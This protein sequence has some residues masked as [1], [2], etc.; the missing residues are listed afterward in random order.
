MAMSLWPHFLAHPVISPQLLTFT[1]R[2]YY[3][4]FLNVTLAGSNNSAMILDMY[5]VE[6]I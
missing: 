2:E 1:A 6:L 5:S 3:V 4:I